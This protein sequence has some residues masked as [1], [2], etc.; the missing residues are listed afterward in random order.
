M[1]RK[2]FH[3]STK[4]KAEIKKLP[5]LCSVIKEHAMVEIRR[6]SIYNEQMQR[7]EPLRDEF[8][9]CNSISKCGLQS[10]D[11]QGQVS[12]DRER[13]PACLKVKA[14]ATLQ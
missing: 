2:A 5:F 14:K 8:L 9:D 7:Y 13:C 6:T 4:P 10:T 11:A 1:M 3:R 12:F